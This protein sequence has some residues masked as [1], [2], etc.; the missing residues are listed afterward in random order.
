MDAYR[1]TI[2]KRMLIFGPF[3]LVAVILG[4]LFTFF[5]GRESME[6]LVLAFQRGIL[7]GLGSSALVKTIHYIKILSNDE[8]LRREYNQENDERLK[9]IRAKAGLPVMWYSSVI[10]LAAG[11]IA[12]YFNITIFATLA[13]TGMFLLVFSSVLRFVYMKIM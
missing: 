8:L 9:A 3:S 6:N 5:F 1:K 11:I 10:I 12:G 4:V 13:I 2:K 7:I